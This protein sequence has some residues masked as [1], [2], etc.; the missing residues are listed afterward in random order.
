[1]TTLD[2]VNR[3]LDASDFDTAFDL[4]EGAAA[5]RDPAQAAT[6]RLLE[7]AV[8]ALYGPDGLQGGNAALTEAATLDRAVLNRPL[9]KALRAEFDAYQLETAARGNPN[10]NVPGD[11]RHDRA[12]ALAGEVSG[13]PLA[14]YHAAAALVTL[15]EPEAGLRGFEA[16]APE[17]LPRHL[18]WR[19]WSWRGGAYEDLGRYREAVHAYGTAATL[20]DG[21]DR[22]ALLLDKAAMALEL[23]EP[24]DVLPI[25][26]EAKAA[27]PH[28]EGPVDEAARLYLEARAH[29][30][31]NNPSLAAERAE[32]ARRLEREAGEPSY[33]AALVHGQALATLEQFGPALEAF[34]EAVRLAT[35]VDRG[36][37]LHEYGLTQMDADLL[38]EARA[39]LIE[40]ANVTDYPHRGEV[41]ADLAELESRAGNFEAAE[42]AARQA[43][44]LGAIV[45]GN[46]ML[47]SLAAEDFR[48]DDALAHYHTVAG[49][50]PEGSREW[51]IAHEMIA[52]TLV[53]AG[54]RNP[55]EILEHA[56]IAVKHLEP[57]D[58]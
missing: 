1:M 50:A 36:F 40:A 3:A 45:P 38:G 47:A 33:G 24:H 18:Q 9:F 35:G 34:A 49:A 8:Y 44:A 2:A 56:G 15:G 6:Y 41:L 54:W 29:L 21:P 10:L 31:L 17:G 12:A 4:I 53:Q 20:A 11:S 14:L 43:V 55:A 37:A 25:L 23:E 27:Y 51:V 5:T 52:D 57:S 42:A 13:E 58:E 28:G 39:S 30:E 26:D 16:I 32:R 7:A 46:L 48:L 19:F 22:A